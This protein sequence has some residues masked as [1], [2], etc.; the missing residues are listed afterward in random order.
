MK[1]HWLAGGFLLVAV[2]CAS[3]KVLVKTAAS[4][5]QCAE[6]EIKTYPQDT[7]LSHVEGC[8]RKNVYLYANGEWS[9]PLRRASFDLD[10]PNWKLRVRALDQTTVGV[11]GC[12]R[13]ATYVLDR[14]RG[15]WVLNSETK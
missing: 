3:Q 10:C 7:Y 6:S 14:I 9:S 5:L 15:A 2:G 1:S 11:A 4:E 12:E 13:K 8:G